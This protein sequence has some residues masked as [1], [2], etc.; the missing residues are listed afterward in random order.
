MSKD[1]VTLCTTTWFTTESEVGQRDSLPPPLFA[2][3]I[4]DLT[5]G[6]NQLNMGVPFDNDKMCILS[7]IKHDVI[8]YK[9]MLT[10]GFSA[11]FWFASDVHCFI[12]LQTCSMLAYLEH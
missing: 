12:T 2:I 1:K 8:A 5:K 3:Y 11:S 9:A 4:N 10:A 6:M 7:Q